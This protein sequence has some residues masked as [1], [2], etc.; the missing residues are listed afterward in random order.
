MRI[1]LFLA[2]VNSA[3]FIQCIGCLKLVSADRV[4]RIRVW[5]NVPVR[6]YNNASELI[7]NNPFAIFT[8]LV[9]P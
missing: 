6:I 8:Y 1:L 4:D 9:Q 2:I 3:A 5:C 7:I